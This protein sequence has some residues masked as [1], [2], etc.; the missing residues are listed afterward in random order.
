MNNNI[1]A[2]VNEMKIK[3]RKDGRY[4]G[5][6]TVNGIRKS[7][8]GKTKSSVKKNAKEYLQKV[9]NGYREPEK[10]KTND[11]IE[12]WL[13]AYK[14]NKIEPSSYSRLIVTYNNQIKNT[15][16]NKLI[17]KLETSDIQKLIDEY[18]NPT[19]KN[20]KP[21]AISGLKKIIHLLNP[22]LK[23]AVAEGIID[24]NPCKD[25]IFPVES[26][27]CV[28]TKKQISLSDKEI[29][30]FRA[31][32]LEKYE[33]NGEY[34]SRD[35]FVL[36]LILNLGLRIGEAMALNW[37]DFDFG[38]R[39][40]YIN[41]TIQTNIKNANGA[42]DKKICSRIKN[43]AKTINGVRVLKLNEQ[44][45]FYLNELKNY[46]KRNNITS[47]Y[48]C[49][50]HNNTLNT[51][52]NLQ[53]SLDRIVKRTSINEKVTLHTLRHTFGSVLVRRGVGIEVVSSLMGHANISITYNKY[54]HV[55]QEQKAK[56]MDMINVC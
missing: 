15:I 55:V 11:Y 41:K 42:D 40:V 51:P 26:C 45:M 38:D 10:I 29:D 37:S 24:K 19:N 54:I 31:S 5:R 9:E 33:S 18:A 6:I 35:A 12:Y 27:I 7:F 44:A 23:K 32:A 16:G 3:E 36:L 34:K 4:E 25:V 13:K 17:G 52:R 28:K 1:S 21:L 14:L 47:P 53:R 50:T 39:I 22:C 8:Y 30:E 56:A 49:S 2:I 46:D 48:L 43:T 20:T